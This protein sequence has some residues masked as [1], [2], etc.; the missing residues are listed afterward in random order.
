MNIGTLL[1]NLR[2]DRT[3]NMI[4][5]MSDIHG[6]K[7]RFESVLSQI[8]LKST[9]RLYILGDVIDRFPDG[10]ELLQRIRQMKNARL[11]LGNHEYMMLNAYAE[12][13]GYRYPSFTPRE[14]WGHWN[15]NHCSDTV[16]GFEQL[17]KAEQKD[18]YEYLLHRK[19]YL[20]VTVGGQKYLLVH[21]SSP[22]GYTGERRLTY[23]SLTEYVVWVRCPDSFT[24]DDG[25]I[26][27]FGHTP[28]AYYQNKDPMTIWHGN[29][30]V[31][32]DCGAGFTSKNVGV[33]CRLACLRLDDMKEFYS[34][35]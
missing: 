4:Y 34:E 25:S 29:N 35:E 31:G 13:F 19:R 17:S 20:Y 1:K 8:N 16:R 7:K 11:L 27:I 28:T 5:V 24:P 12:Q 10:I 26:M 6:N 23:E 21:G 30:I 9:D 14:A 32:I 15:N 2:K 18:L 22:R 33:G 3:H